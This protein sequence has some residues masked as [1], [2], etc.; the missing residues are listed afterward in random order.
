[1]HGWRRWISRGARGAGRGLDAGDG[2]RA[3]GR[4]PSPPAWRVCQPGRDRC[5]R[6]AGRVRAAG[7]GP[8]RSA[9][10][11]ALATSEGNP[12]VARVTVNR[13]WAQY[14]AAVWSRP[15]KT[16]GSQGTPPTHPELLDWLATEPTPRR[17]APEGVAPPDRHVGDLSAVFA[18]GG[19]G[20]GR[21]GR[22]RP[23]FNRL[24]ARAPHRRL[25][26]GCRARRDVRGQRASRRA[27]RRPA[28]VSAAAGGRS[29]KRRANTARASGATHRHRPAS[30][31]R[32]T[33]SGGGPRRT[34]ARAIALTR[35]AARAAPCAAGER[36]RP[37]QALA[38]LN[39]PAFWEAA[40]ALGRRMRDEARSA[41]TSAR[42]DYGFHLCT[43]RPAR[44]RELQVAARALRTGARA[45]R[46]RRCVVAGGQRSL[47]LDETLSNH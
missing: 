40:R 17:V 33:R 38:T 11:R 28:G 5:R 27:R 18:S 19:R 43:A 41:D 14:S 20:R 12:L 4:D 6:G 16:F 7:R 46:R 32:S 2:G 23:R 25:D 35:P 29:L 10:A 3:P 1:M 26:A 44:A 13:I 9:R 36:A 34:R 31:A 42:I 24:L 39:H 21:A 37:A 22:A 47:N 30:G 45:A 15:A 8:A